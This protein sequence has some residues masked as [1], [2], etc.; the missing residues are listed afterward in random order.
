MTFNKE[1][2]KE[3]AQTENSENPCISIY[4]PTHRT[5]ENR[6]DQLRFK[7][8]VKEAHNGLEQQGMEEK[9]AHTYLNKAYELLD[10]DDF[11]MH[12]SD[13][14]AVFITEGKFE[15]FSVPEHFTALTYVGKNYHLSPMLPLITG[16]DRFFILALS[17]NEVRFFE[18]RRASIYPVII[19]DLVPADLE[20]ANFDEHQKT[21]QHHSAGD[22]IFHG[23]GGANADKN[24][25]I[26]RYFRE[27]DEGLMKMLH[28]E[29][30]PLI[31]AAVDYLVPIYKGI[32]DYSNVVEMHISG[33]PEN[34]SPTDLHLAAWEK[35]EGH[36]NKEQTEVTE[37]FKGYLSE[38]KAS[39]NNL[40]VIPAAINGRVDTLWVNSEMHDYG[41]FDKKTNTVKIETEPTSN[42]RC[43]LDWA[44]TQ[45]YLQGGTVYYVPRSEMPQPVENVN[46]IL[47]Y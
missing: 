38:K 45:T 27:V 18:G 8:A 9:E 7:N 25:R 31:I 10:N 1:N 6:E 43:L 39:F 40:D 35:L 46:A 2:F 30:V 26:E 14:L 29:K 47:R 28:D 32:S 13:G 22:A 15:H 3:L 4:I 17:Q 41:T 20:A 23:Q 33:N 16:K 44:A 42:N 19:G 11:W 36:F 21:L 34:M 12:Q 5:G 37:N 24:D